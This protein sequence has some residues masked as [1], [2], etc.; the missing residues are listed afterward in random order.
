[1]TIYKPKTGGEKPQK[2]I[3]VPALEGLP[4]EV[5]LSGGKKKITESSAH[6]IIVT[7]ARRRRNH[8]IAAIAFLLFLCV[9]AFSFG[10][11]LFIFRHMR[12]SYT[13]FCQVLY[14]EGVTAGQFQESVEIDTANGL[15][16]KL[17]VPSVLDSKRSTV[18]HD[19]DKNLTAIVDKDRGN[20]FVMDLNRTVVQPPQSFYD[21]LVKAQS[22]YYIPDAEVIREQYRVLE[23]EIEDIIPFGDFIYSECQNFDTYRLIRADEPYAMSRK[24]S[25]NGPHIRQVYNLGETMGKYIHFVEIIQ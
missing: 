14:H 24:R 19:F 15:Y 18:V 17:H 4:E 22:G 11:G 25:V 20:C 8:M 7:P 16:E 21:L 12:R 9:A 10:F 23:S 3:K 2:G 13:G 1:M 6:L 5:A